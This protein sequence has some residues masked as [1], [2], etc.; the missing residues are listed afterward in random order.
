MFRD[1]DKKIYFT[2]A[3]TG[4]AIWIAVWYLW[5]DEIFTDNFTGTAV[6]AV[7]FI[8]IW[9]IAVIASRRKKNRP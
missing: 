1:Q 8:F 2:V 3:L 9:A 6:L 5:L 4:I 7:G